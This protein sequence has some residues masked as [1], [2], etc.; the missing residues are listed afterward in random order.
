MSNEHGEHDDH[1]CDFEKSNDAAILLAQSASELVDCHT[2]AAAALLIAAEAHAR[3]AGA[4]DSWA[5]LHDMVDNFS[6]ATVTGH[7]RI[8]GEPG[9]PS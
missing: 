9:D 3:A 8:D 4:P 2:E 1:E 7:V 6:R 5:A